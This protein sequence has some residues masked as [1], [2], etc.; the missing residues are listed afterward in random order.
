MAQD[1]PKDWR[2]L[3]EATA[4]EQDPYK[5]LTLVAQII[6]ALDERDRQRKK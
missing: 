4:N 3:R 1:Q 5:L 2:K 6:I